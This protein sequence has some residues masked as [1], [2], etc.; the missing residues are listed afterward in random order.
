MSCTIVTWRR[1][2]IYEIVVV[3][4][5]MNRSLLTIETRN[6]TSPKVRDVL[7]EVSSAGAAEQWY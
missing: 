1:F 7:V 2:L 6:P 4:L 3:I 5:M